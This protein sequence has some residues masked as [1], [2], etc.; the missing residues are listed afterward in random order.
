MQ[1]PSSPSFSLEGIELSLAG[2]LGVT[3]ICL[4]VAVLSVPEYPT[5]SA[6]EAYGQ[7]DRDHIST[8]YAVL[9]SV[10]TR[11]MVQQA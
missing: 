7:C 10:Q 9:F 5:G 3:F 1:A 8:S 4:N 2:T 6:T 11:W